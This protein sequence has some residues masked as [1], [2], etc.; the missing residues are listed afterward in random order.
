MSNLHFPVKIL[1]GGLQVSFQV[2]ENSALK[3]NSKTAQTVTSRA[4]FLR[5]GFLNIVT[6]S[7]PFPQYVRHH[8]EDTP[9]C[10]FNL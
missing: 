10:D 1:N 5:L 7:P 2:F 3:E 8:L 4:R 6:S 9:L